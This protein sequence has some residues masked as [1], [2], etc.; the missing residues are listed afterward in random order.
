MDLRLEGKCALVTGASEG[1]GKSVAIALA[2]EGANVAI[3]ARRLDILEQARNEIARA[4]RGRVKAIA[5]D[6]GVAEEIDRVRREAV[7]DLGGLDIL[8]NNMGAS[9]AGDDDRTWEDMFRLNLLASVRMTRAV[10][11]HLKDRAKTGP[12]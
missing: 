3:C 11:P 7:T 12:N 5:G 1:I 4:G 2:A 6:L 8:V 10:L 9:L